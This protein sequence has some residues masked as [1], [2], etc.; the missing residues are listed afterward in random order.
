M[1]YLWKMVILLLLNSLFTVEGK[2]LLS[3]RRALSDTQQLLQLQAISL[4]AVLDSNGLTLRIF[5]S[6]P[7]PL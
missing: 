1:K 6:P 2:G 5:S 3:R 4:K 7:L